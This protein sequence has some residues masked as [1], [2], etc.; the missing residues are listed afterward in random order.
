MKQSDWMLKNFNQSKCLKIA[1][2]NIPG[3]TVLVGD[4]HNC[5]VVVQLTDWPACFWMWRRRR[6]R[7]SCQWPTRSRWGHRRRTAKAK[8]LK[9]FLKFKFP[10]IFA[11]NIRVKEDNVVVSIGVRN[12]GRLMARL[13]E[14]NVKWNY[15]H[16]IQCDQIGRFIARWATF[17]SLWQ[18]LIFPNLPHS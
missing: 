17:H 2:H 16:C 8:C 12:I 18:Q 13:D 9:L 3:H 5:A 4:S 11:N 6:W 1:K 15:L 14:R 10:A 7:A